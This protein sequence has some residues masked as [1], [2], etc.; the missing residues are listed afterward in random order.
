MLAQLRLLI[1][2]LLGIAFFGCVRG[3]S[4]GDDDSNPA[5]PP[6]FAPNGWPISSAPDDYEGTGNREGDFAYDFKAT[7]QNGN[8]TWL[9]QFFGSMVVLDYSAVW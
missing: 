5:T 3:G 8:E 1:L 9:N 7:D 4:Q 2:P 6:L